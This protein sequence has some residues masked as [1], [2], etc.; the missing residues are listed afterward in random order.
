MSSK[1]STTPI[2]ENGIIEAK[3]SIVS[4]IE[5]LNGF[6][7]KK[8]SRLNSLTQEMTGPLTRNDRH[9]M[10]N[11]TIIYGHELSHG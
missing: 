10:S 6:E 1:G 7:I 4:S 8:N 2:R 11:G 5:A 3:N 9:N